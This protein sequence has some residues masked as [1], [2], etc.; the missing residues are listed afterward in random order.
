[1]TIVDS[2]LKKNADKKKQKLL[3]T[4]STFIRFVRT[5]KHAVAYVQLEDTNIYTGS[6]NTLVSVAFCERQSPNYV[7]KVS[8]SISETM[9]NQLEKRFVSKKSILR[10]ACIFFL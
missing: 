7:M 9:K 6:R 8:S 10:I 4:T 1:M 2:F 3:P 5:V